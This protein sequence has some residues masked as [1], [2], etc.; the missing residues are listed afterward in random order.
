MGKSRD[1]HGKRGGGGGGG[2]GGGKVGKASPKSGPKHS[3]DPTGRPKGKG[4]TQR[5]E[6][7][8][9]ESKGQWGVGQRRRLHEEDNGECGGVVRGVGGWAG[10]GFR[11]TILRAHALV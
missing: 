1:G 9:R 6:A 11:H 2:V 4:N 3:M 10:R 5:T 7:T 8:V